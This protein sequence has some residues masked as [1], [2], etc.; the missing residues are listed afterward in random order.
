MHGVDIDV[1][2]VGVRASSVHEPVQHGWNIG[3]ACLR[4]S[5]CRCRTPHG[6]IISHLHG[7]CSLGS[8]RAS[9][10]ASSGYVVELDH[11]GLHL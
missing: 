11:V 1:D 2:G 8:P 5:P 3:H 9:S 4:R 7:W 6:V 10:A